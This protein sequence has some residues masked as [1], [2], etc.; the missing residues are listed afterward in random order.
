MLNVPVHQSRVPRRVL[1]VDE[2]ELSF[3][4][5]QQKV[6]LEALR[7]LATE[8]LVVENADPAWT[9][10]LSDEAARAPVG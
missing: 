8:R 3:T 1:F 10:F 2:T 7:A 9:A 6:Q 4:S 5:S